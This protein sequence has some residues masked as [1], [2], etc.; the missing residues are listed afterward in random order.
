MCVFLASLL[1]AMFLFSLVGCT[2]TDPEDT[3]PAQSQQEITTQE[4]EQPAEPAESASAPED[5]TPESPDIEPNNDAENNLKYGE[6]VSVN[7]NRTSNGIV[8]IKA[9]IAANI[10]D[11]LTV[12]QNYHNAVDLIQNQGYADCELQ[13]WAVADMSSGS[14]DKVIS[15]TIPQDLVAQISAGDVVATQLGDLVED[16][17]IHPSLK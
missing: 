11:S 8:V 14:E 7:D 5:A 13:Y 17:Y 6:L 10:T 9:K 16:L 15:F 12:S 4:P 3:T 1:A 2:L